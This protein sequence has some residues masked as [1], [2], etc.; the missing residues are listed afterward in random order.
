[1]CKD[2]FLHVFY[3]SYTLFH[4]LVHIKVLDNSVNL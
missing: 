2:L 3:D 1:M 4:L